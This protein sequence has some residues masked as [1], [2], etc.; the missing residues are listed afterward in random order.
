MCGGPFMTTRKDATCCSA[1]CRQ[2]LSRH[3]RGLQSLTPKQEMH[4]IAATT[5]PVPAGEL[6]AVKAAAGKATRTKKGQGNKP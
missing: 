1:R 4:L 2:T 6:P 3:A 5:Q